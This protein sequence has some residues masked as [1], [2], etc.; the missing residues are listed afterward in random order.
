MNQSDTAGNVPVQSLTSINAVL[1]KQLEALTGIEAILGSERE[2]LRNREPEKLLIAANA[3]A[4]ALARLSELENQRK[5]I[6][7]DIDSRQIETLRDLT[8]RCKSMN[9]DNAALLNAQQQHV[10]R[11]L[12]LLRGTS[13]NKPSS[14]DASGKTSRATAQQLRL[15]QV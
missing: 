3:K 7:A 8:Q 10:N 14:Y 15:T 11:L 13:D 2:A 1:Q 9:L 6:S 12:G 5:S 4:E